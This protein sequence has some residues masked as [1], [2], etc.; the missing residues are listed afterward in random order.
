MEES[1]GNKWD[2]LLGL[3]MEE[4]FCV[5]FCSLYLYG[6]LVY[7]LQR[8]TPSAN[9]EYIQARK[10]MY[11]DRRKDEFHSYGCCYHCIAAANHVVGY[12]L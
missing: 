10:F 9:T 2:L 12:L 3:G 4:V 1:I 6:A 8:S 5:S 7:F 11:N